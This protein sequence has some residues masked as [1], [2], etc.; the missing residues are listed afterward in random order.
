[1]RPSV[2]FVF[3]VFIFS[4]AAF[5]QRSPVFLQPEKTPKLK[6]HRPKGRIKP[7]NPKNF[8]QPQTLGT[9]HSDFPNIN[10]SQWFFSDQNETAIAINPTDGK[11][12]IVGANDYRSF[13]TLWYFTSTDGGFTWKSQEL[14]VDQ[15]LAFATDPSVGFGPDGVGYYTNGR[16][17]HGGSPY[18]LNDVVTYK[19]TTKGL[20]WDA[21]VRVFFDSDNVASASTLAD[22]YY[23]AVAPTAP[24]PLPPKLYVAWAEYENEK[25]RIVISR[26]Q[27]GGATWSPRVGLTAFGKFQAPIP[28]VATG[29]EVYVAFIDLD[30]TK[31]EILFAKSTDG[32]QT[33]TT[34]KKIAN[35]NHLGPLHPPNSPHPHPIIKGHLRVNSFPSIAIDHSFKHFN[36]IYTTWAGKGQD[37]KHHIYLSKSDDFGATWSEAL[38]IENDKSALMTDKFFPWVAVDPTNGDV[39]VCFYDSRLD[40]PANQMTDLFLGISE[41]GGE[42]FSV[43]RISDRSFNPS[44]SASVDSTASVDTLSFFGDYNG[45][46]AFN[47]MWYPVWTDSREGYDQDIYIGIVNPRLPEGVKDLEVQEETGSHFPV[48]T[49]SHSGLTTFGAPL[50]EYVFRIKRSDSASIELPSS[51]RTFHDSSVTTAT[52][53]TYRATVVASERSSIAQEVRF[54]PFA[55]RKP[56]A[57]RVITSRAEGQP[58]SGFFVRFRIPDKNVVGDSIL[59]LKYLY[60]FIDGVVADSFKLVDAMRGSELE[61]SFSAATGYHTFQL[62]ATSA[63]GGEIVSSDTSAALWLY[64]GQP[65]EMYFESFEETKDIFTT[66]AWETTSIGLPSTFI[67]DSLPNVPYDSGVNSW[68]LLP[69]VRI[70]AGIHTLEFDHMAL[71]AAGD[72]ALIEVSLDNG[73]SYFFVRRYDITSEGLKWNHT[74]FDSETSSDS[75][76]FKAHI[77]KDVVVRFRL[78]GA[79]PT[80]ADG[81][82]ID[83]IR[84]TDKLSVGASTSV[85]THT[86]ELRPSVVHYGS[87][88]RGELTL[89]ES[90]YVTIEIADMLGRP[91]GEVFAPRYIPAGAYIV[92]FPA[93]LS[94]AYIVTATVRVPGKPVSV[95]RGR[96]I[97]RP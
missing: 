27:D 79:N 17:A 70:S 10:I 81:W 44:V 57:P 55:V 13:N 58:E 32:A 6:W 82:L 35:Y 38:P 23:L 15:A 5:G 88:V 84:F 96:F 18:P 47:G 72:S 49:W 31:R 66:K 11:N 73:V 39:G 19:S 60:Y 29:G 22:K 86:L 34:P 75:I 46:A 97:V 48:L 85:P 74:I 28:T 42:T 7:L 21:P 8:H 91:M 77:G 1:M 61:R 33:F 65:R 16:L 2:F 59:D 56:E 76:A 45:L 20:S 43:Q 25:S 78:A 89:S 30:T 12:I 24:G 53:Y 63:T 4:E 36:R 9:S 93:P 37:G 68:M 14:P 71:V 41:D 83:N 87:D 40:A 26:S 64:A 67:N 69:P 90:G 52:T 50:G 94:G 3:I 54:I 62:A 95:V 92:E 80:G 51:A